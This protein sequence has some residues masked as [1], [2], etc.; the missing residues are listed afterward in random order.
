MAKPYGPASDH[1][2]DRCLAESRP[3]RMDRSRVP[4]GRTARRGPALDDRVHRPRSRDAPSRARRRS[5]RLAR[6][7]R[8]EAR[9]RGLLLLIGV[10][11]ADD[12]RLAERELD[13]PVVVDP[14][15]DPVL[16]RRR[17]RPRSRRSRPTVSTLSFFFSAS[18][19]SCR[20]F[21]CLLLGA[22]HEE[23]EQQD[24]DGDR[25]QRARRRRGRRRSARAVRRP[26][27][28]AWARSSGERGEQSGHR[29]SWSVGM[30]R[31][32]GDRRP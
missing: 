17:P 23:V 32:R 31:Q 21:S 10:D 15:D 1:V 12:A 8:L 18:I 20:F 6:R 30:S 4:N 29:S 13:P 3:R 7:R 28:R 24:D 14:Q 25:Q 2:D 5:A 9:L 11:H 22:D 27:G 16:I 26:R 19:I